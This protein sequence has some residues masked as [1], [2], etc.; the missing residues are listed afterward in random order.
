NAARAFENNPELFRLRYLETLKEAGAGYG[1]QLIIG[2]PEEL[3]GA[4]KK[5]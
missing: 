3:M 1:N 2:V 5:D 4:V